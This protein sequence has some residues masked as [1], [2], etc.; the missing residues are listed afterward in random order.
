MVREI[1]DLNDDMAASMRL[2]RK[3]IR[4][5]PA[6]E[7]G[8]KGAHDRFTRDTAILLMALEETSKILESSR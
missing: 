2:L 7:Q 6:E 5:V 1:D 4:G 8:F 3:A